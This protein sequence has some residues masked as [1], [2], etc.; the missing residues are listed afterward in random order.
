MRNIATIL[1]LTI[2]SCLFSI[3]VHA[4]FFFGPGVSTQSAAKAGMGDGLCIRGLSNL[5]AKNY[6]EAYKYL[7]QAYDE[8]DNAK[9]AAYLGIMFEHGLG[10]S[11]NQDKARFFYSWSQRNGNSFGAGN[12]NRINQYGFNDPTPECINHVLQIIRA[13]E[14]MN[15]T[16]GYYGSPELNMGSSGSSNSA[17]PGCGGTGACSTCDGVGYWTDSTGEKHICGVCRGNKRCG[18]C[19]GKGH[20]E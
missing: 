7:Y 14:G 5:V 16:P 10:V 17:C 4:Q 11:V 1:I 13:R 8:Y 20:V 19:R 3:E 9:A 18:V 2:C 15:S 6:S 12:L